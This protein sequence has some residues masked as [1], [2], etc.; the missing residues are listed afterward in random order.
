MNEPKKS[1]GGRQDGAGRP[2]K[3]DEEKKKRIVAYVEPAVA[4]WIEANG[5]NKFAAK[6]LAQAH[7][8]S[9]VV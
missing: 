3:A 5:G 6:L 7:I 1:F 8:E 4:D 2:V 9:L